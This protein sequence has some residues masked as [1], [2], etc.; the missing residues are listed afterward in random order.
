MHQGHGCSRAAQL[1]R[2]DRGRVLAPDDHDRAAVP[3]VGLVVV[4]GHVREVFAGHP[5]AVRV[6]IV[7]GGEHHAPRQPRALARP[8]GSSAN[9]EARGLARD[10]LHLFAES[11][12]QPIGVGHAAV[13]AQRFPLRRLLVGRDERQ[14]ADL[15][16]VGSGEERHRP[17][18]VEDRVDE[19]AFLDDLVVE[20]RAVR[21]DGHGQARRPRPDDQQI[22]RFVSIP[23]ILPAKRATV[24]SPAQPQG[25]GCSSAGHATSCVCKSL[26]NKHLTFLLS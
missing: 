3:G 11:D 4:V 17:R 16:E 2:G 24:R 14:A 10:R 21:G 8:R 23:P 20:T 1:E 25:M 13:V 22:A 26:L 6:V 7:A 15:Q 5:E 9:R 18:K 12:P 19:H